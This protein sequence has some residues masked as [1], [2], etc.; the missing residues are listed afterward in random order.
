MRSYFEKDK[1]I[2]CVKRNI[3][4]LKLCKLVFI[5]NDRNNE[6]YKT[7]IIFNMF[8]SA[9]REHSQGKY[10]QLLLRCADRYVPMAL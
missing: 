6:L 5:V 10:L 4:K 7:P 8:R 2:F 9:R 1:F 3:Q